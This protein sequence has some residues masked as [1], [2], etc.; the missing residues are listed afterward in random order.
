MDRMWERYKAKSE[1]EEKKTPGTWGL[2]GAG[3][4]PEM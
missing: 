1:S 4:A 2:L 3:A